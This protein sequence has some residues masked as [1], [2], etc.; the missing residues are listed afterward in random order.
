MSSFSVNPPVFTVQTV[1]FIV[2]SLT[3][4]SKLLKS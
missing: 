1:I 2:G 4:V 3:Q